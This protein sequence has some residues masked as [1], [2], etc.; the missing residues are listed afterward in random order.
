M[1]IYGELYA[2]EKWCGE[3][4]GSGL[5]LH[6]FHGRYADSVRDVPCMYCDGSG[7]IQNEDF[8]HEPD[9]LLES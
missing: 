4:D 3:C 5:V 6:R 9:D 8:E 7:K 2:G 1:G